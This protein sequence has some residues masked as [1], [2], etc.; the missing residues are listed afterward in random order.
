MTGYI[1]LGLVGVVFW[2]LFYIEAKQH[3]ET[4]RQQ[5]A[6]NLAEI[7]ALIAGAKTEAKKL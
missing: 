7:K 1:I 6:D 2:L 3:N 5:F 4:L